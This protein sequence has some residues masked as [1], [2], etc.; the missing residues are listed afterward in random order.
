LKSNLSRTSHKEEEYLTVYL[1]HIERLFSAMFRLL[2][3]IILEICVTLTFAAVRQF[4]QKYAINCSDNL[5]S[6]NSE[7]EK[8]TS[9]FRHNFIQNFAICVPV[10]ILV[11]IICYYI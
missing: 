11:S 6:I 3:L 10:V 8:H 9:M 1:V 4:V 5:E 2:K 7:T